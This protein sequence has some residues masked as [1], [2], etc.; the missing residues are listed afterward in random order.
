M[1]KILHINSHPLFEKGT[2][3]TVQLAKHGL[4]LLQ[5]LPD[6]EI[7]TLNL[8]S[9][10]IF[11][12][13]VD[14]L[15]FSMW[16]KQGNNITREEQ[17]I[18]DVQNQL[19][20]QWIAADYIFIY[21]PLHNFNVTAKFKDYVDNLMIAGRTFRYTKTGSVGLLDP[22]KKVV[23][24]QSSGSDYRSDITYVNADIAPHYVRTILSFMGIKH[25]HLIS[26]QG[27]D[28]SSNDRDEVIS[29]AKREITKYI[30]TQIE[31]PRNYRMLSSEV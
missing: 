12:P 19:I 30:R 20:D 6:V 21:S 9:K 18:F 11:I 27:L 10:D 29:D 7:E 2:S 28:M 26:A 15:M 5:A 1:K 16:S 31:A 3:S 24:V 25:M 8:Y 13:R 23:Y 4:S 17:L 22:A 14:E